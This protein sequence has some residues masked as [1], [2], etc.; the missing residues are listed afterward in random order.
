MNE[1]Q[2]LIRWFPDKNWNWIEL[3]RNPNITMGDVIAYPD[4][5]WDW[6]GLLI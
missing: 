4:K 3:S 6:E 2:M 1:L 5:P